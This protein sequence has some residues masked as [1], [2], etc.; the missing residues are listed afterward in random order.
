MMG[1]V[2]LLR[3]RE[4]LHPVCSPS[5]EDATRRWKSAAQNGALT[6]T[7]LCW[8]PDLALPVSR[9]AKSKAILLFISHTGDGILL[10][11]LSWT[12]TLGQT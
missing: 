10:L 11:Q 8:L 6:R 9:T 4:H 1:L 5:S 3:V 2:S 12:E 7:P